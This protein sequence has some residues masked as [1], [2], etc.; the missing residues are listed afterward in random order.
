M[1]GTGDVLDTHLFRELAERRAAAVIQDPDFEFIFR[2]VDT[3]RGV[4]RVFYHAQ[5]FVV[6]RHEEIDRRPL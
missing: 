6:G 2:P 1:R 4:N 5:V 3:Q